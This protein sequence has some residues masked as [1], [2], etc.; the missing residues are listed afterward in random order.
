MKLE[1][2]LA[3]RHLVFRPGKTLASILGIAVGIATVVSVLVVDHNTLR[4]EEMLR[5]QADP[6]A[7]LLI[8]PDLSS[9]LAVDEVRDD[10]AAQPLLSGVAAFAT[11]HLALRVDGRTKAGIEL[12]AVDEAARTHHG[13][14]AVA[15]GDDL[16]F[17]SDVP[18]LLVA[19]DVAERAGI[20]V[21]DI[22]ELAR[23]P[24]RRVP[25]VECVG[26]KLVEI[27]PEQPPAP[28][29][30]RAA[31]APQPEPIHSFRVA[32]ILQPTR[33]GFAGSRVIT[34]FAQGAEVMGR[35]LDVRFW[36]DFDKT[37]T[38][39]PTLRRQLEDR[40]QVDAP[41]RS[42]VGLAPEER[43]FRSGVRFCGFLALFLGLYI[44]FNTMSMSLVERVRSIGL[45]RALGLTQ[46]RLLVVFMAEGLVLAALG[47]GLSLLL[48]KGITGFMEE[49]GI[50][51]L[52]TGRPL[53]IA[54]I[55]WGPVAWVLV[56][57]MVFSLLGVLYPFARASRLSVIDA[58]R[59]GVIELSRDPFTGV[60][61]S[62]LIGLLAVV[63]VAWVVGAPADEYVP[64]PLY[65]ALLVG[66]AVVGGAFA[67]L[68]LVP[69]L[70]EAL[71][72]LLTAPFRGPAGR[73]CRST[74][75]SARHRVF[76]TV[77]GLMLVFTAIFLIVTVLES[78]KAET[79]AF[80][81]RALAERLYIKMSPEGAASVP[82]LRK[83]APE[84]RTLMPLNVEVTS[85][86]V[87]RAIGSS[88]LGVGSLAKDTELR[89]A[90]LEEPTILLS[91][92]CADDF[93][94]HPGDTVRLSTRSSGFV[95]FRVLAVTDEYGFAPDDR[96]FGVISSDAMLNYWCLDAEGLGDDFVSW[97]PG[98]DAQRA[99]ELRALC[100]DVL[101]EGNLLSFRRGEEITAEYVADLDS[102]FSIFYAILAL[103]VLLAAVG[104]LNAMVIAVMERRREIGLL[105]AVGL[106]GGQVV[107]ML[108]VESGVLGVLGGLFGLLLGIPLAVVTCD[109]LTAA[110][111]L[112]LAFALSPRALGA[113]LA[114]AVAI[115]VLAVILPA[116]RANR[117]RLSEVMR[118]E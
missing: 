99:D 15:E 38:D 88:M 116:L 84:L 39:L 41:T 36:A 34:T 52:G 26:G 110:S 45:L 80:G 50:T 30:G 64:E 61:R 65:R 68:L 104:I 22:V 95:E 90:F 69:Q 48:A 97:A 25:E 16:D 81:E 5:G 107:A 18:Q 71:T 83:A 91:T 10:L 27:E 14:Y 73:L 86:F 54:E 62:V 59:R 37:R 113:V 42:L 46:R 118:Y 78:L 44:I 96:V 9:A 94:K 7:D 114:G 1:L 6:E 67:L 31:A 35:H 66:F 109:A 105:R 20:A 57:G 24:A 100:A 12:F 43:A 111:H 63:P 2:L 33:L 93:D 85:S 58:L 103:T 74:L 21:G 75:S 51:T 3:W 115:S 70:L 101:G 53:V 47:A 11:A 72:R 98:V 56:S 89:R 13:A 28:K 77:S 4:T 82:E 40:Y 29:G 49:R 108:M 117:F 60:R 17:T 79:R 23:P 32:G 55:P 112:E 106:T 87:V 76:G 19:Q 102:N 92:R 8:Q